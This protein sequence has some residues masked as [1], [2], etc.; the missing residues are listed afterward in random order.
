MRFAL[1]IGAIFLCSIGC[2]P[3]KYDR[4]VEYIPVYSTATHGAFAANSRHHHAITAL[5]AGNLEKA[6]SI[7]KSILAGNSGFGPAHNT[8]GIVY[9]QQGKYYPAAWEF[10]YAKRAMPHHPGP[11]NSLGLIYERV[12]RYPDALQ[13]YAHAI[14]IEP[15]NAEYLGNWV[16]LRIKQGDRS[17]EV[18]QSLQNLLE[19]ET[20]SDWSEWARRQLAIGKFD[21]GFGPESK[22]WPIENPACVI[23]SSD[24]PI[25]ANHCYPEIISES[26]IDE[27][28]TP[29]EFNIDGR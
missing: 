20:R 9:Y 21:Q 10:D 12:Q 11:Y 28:P 14:S 29:S 24:F 26:F 23:S 2:R 7:C 16:R 5:E 25:D 18:Q 3:V 22:I 6:E 19:I 27:L 1:F 13:C 17:F 8:L 15:S 4:S